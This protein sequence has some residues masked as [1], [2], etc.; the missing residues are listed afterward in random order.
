MLECW[1]VGMLECLNVGMLECWNV[2]M[3]F[4]TAFTSG[5]GVF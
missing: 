3:L 4:V 2:G 5:D 1:N